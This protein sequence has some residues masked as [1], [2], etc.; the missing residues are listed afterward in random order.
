M[1]KK[2]LNKI[3]SELEL[4]RLALEKLSPEKPNEPL[5][6]NTNAYLWNSEVKLFTEINE[7]NRIPIK[8]LKGIDSNI[9]ILQENT[10]QFSKK[11]P[12]NN[13]LLWGSRGMGKSSIIKAI[14]HEINLTE[15]N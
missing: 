10:K 6:D 8:L 13:A 14:H 4:I 12:A 15:K 1:E 9:K 2:L 5:W 7:V 11:L 3:C